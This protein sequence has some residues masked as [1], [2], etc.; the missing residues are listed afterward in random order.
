MIIAHGAGDAGSLF[1]SL[2]EG[3]MP[4]ETYDFL[5]SETEQ[6]LTDNVKAMADGW[7]KSTRYIYQR[8]VLRRN[9]ADIS[10]MGTTGP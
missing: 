10:Q 4:R 6:T 7:N 5:T 9:Y 2:F 8:P 3:H 1:H